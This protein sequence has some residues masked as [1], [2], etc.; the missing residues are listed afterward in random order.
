[1]QFDKSL[2]QLLQSVEQ[3]GVCAEK[4]TH[5][6]PTT[7]VD[8]VFPHIIIIMCM[9]GS[10]RVMYD[11]QEITIEKNDLGVLLPGHILRR[12]ACSED[13]TYS[14]ILISAEMSAN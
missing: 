4:E 3:D 2:A 11:M 6:F 12:L 13:Y 9:R 7:G 5:A 1:M 14:C 10:A 8:E